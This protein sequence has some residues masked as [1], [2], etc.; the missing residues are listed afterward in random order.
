[1]SRAE[2]IKILRLLNEETRQKYKGRI[3]GLFG[4]YARGEQNEASDVDLLIE[5]EECLSLFALG[6]MKIFLEER[7]NKKVDIVTT[8]ALRKEIESHIM[9]ELVYI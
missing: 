5:K 8:S 6:G 9:S 4:S 1:M 2:L 7:L 3:I